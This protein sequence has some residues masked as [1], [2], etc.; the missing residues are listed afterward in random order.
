LNDADAE[1]PPEILAVT[2]TLARHVHDTWVL[3]R[4]ADGWSFG[5]RR[6]DE[7]REHPCL[8]PYDE[9]P[10]REKECDR[11]TT[12]ATLRALVILG[13]EVRKIER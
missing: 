13:F 12:L 4:I 11:Q 10:E 7:R 2:E 3:M 6:D 8:V 5:P 9:L 1:L